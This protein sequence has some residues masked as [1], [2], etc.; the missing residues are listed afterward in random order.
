MFGF[1]ND[2]LSV[3]GSFLNAPK[4]WQEVDT[5]TLLLQARQLLGQQKS[6][7]I[8]LYIPSFRI[9][10]GGGGSRFELRNAVNE[11]EGVKSQIGPWWMRH[12]KP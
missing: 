5:S 2:I 1:N 8:I 10:R 11:A 3:V 12:K 9:L 4:N 7:C 6:I